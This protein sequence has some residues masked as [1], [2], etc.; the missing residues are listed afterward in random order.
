ME[1]CSSFISIYDF[2]LTVRLSHERIKK[3]PGG[4]FMIL[5]IKSQVWTI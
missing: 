1:P 4:C 3:C 5:E 2:M